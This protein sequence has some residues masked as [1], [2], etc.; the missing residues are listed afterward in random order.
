METTSKSKDLLAR[1]RSVTLEDELKLGDFWPTENSNAEASTGSSFKTDSLSSYKPSWEDSDF[2]LRSGSRTESGLKTDFLSKSQA[3]QTETEPV[4][5]EFSATSLSSSDPVENRENP[6]AKMSRKSAQLTSKL[7]QK[8][9]GWLMSTSCFG[10]LG[11]VCGG[12]LT[13]WSL[14]AK[15][16]SHSMTALGLSLTISGLLMLVLVGICQ[17]V[18]H[19]SGQ[20]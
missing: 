17:T 10:I 20:T 7:S 18:L 16:G 11:L 4:A 14:L 1:L 8:M 5:R 3:K 9:G 12:S 13:A 2:T 19:T 15:S 6:F